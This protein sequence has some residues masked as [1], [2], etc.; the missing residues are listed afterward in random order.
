M[1]TSYNY[2][3]IEDFLD[4]ILEARTAT[5]VR[6]RLEADEAA[7]AIAKGILML[8]DRFQSE[9]EVTKYLDQRLSENL[10][11]VAKKTSTNNPSYFLKIAASVILLILSGLAVYQLTSPNLKD[12]VADQLASPYK[13]S[14]ALRSSETANNLEKALVLYD[15]RQYQIA[16]DL[17]KSE[18]SP[19]AVFF[20]G[21]SL[22]YLN[23]EMAAIEL[24]KSPAIIDSRYEEQS[25]WYLSL[26]YLQSNQLDQG[27]KLLLRI[28]SRENHFKREEALELLQSIHD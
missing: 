6:S 10:K 27:E 18:N 28:K 17:L 4:G 12:L 26:A 15:N 24:L 8:R 7:Y 1:E 25:L 20:S 19:Q 11:I 21:L 14:F 5:E 2:E 13:A 22:L 23:K 3:L 16:Y 9:T